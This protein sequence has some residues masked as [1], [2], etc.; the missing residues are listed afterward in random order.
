VFTEPAASAAGKIS[1]SSSPIR[2]FSGRVTLSPSVVVRSSAKA[3]GSSAGLTRMGHVVEIQPEGAEARPVHRGRHA[4]P[5]RVADQHDA[6]RAHVSASSARRNPGK[7]SPTEA[8]P[9]TRTGSEASQAC[10]GEGH[11]QPVIA[12]RVTRATVQPHRAAHDEPVRQ[13]LGVRPQRDQSG[14]QP[15]DAVALLRPK[16]DGA[17][18]LGGALGLRGQ[19]ADQRQL[20]DQVG[21]LAGFHRDRVERGSP[22]PQLARR[23]GTVHT[24]RRRL[25]PGPHPGQR[26]QETGPRRIQ[27]NPFDPD[28]R[29][30]DE[31]RGGDQRRGRR[32]ITGHVQA[33]RAEV[34]PDHR[35]DA[36][37]TSVQSAEPLKE[38]LRVVPRWSGFHHGRLAVRPQPG[39]QD[40]RL[41][42]RAGHRELVPDAV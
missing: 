21:D 2:S 25:H 23:F 36:G 31:R 38:A 14:D 6:V 5:H 32:E 33:E 24:D 29:S 30:G 22:H 18:H 7:E 10:H 1:S 37:L 19:H 3:S 8:M 26:V 27:A 39:Q 13:L 42:L 9:A 4:V 34:R 11:G 28:V 15:G 12:E 41:H 35:H 20:V 40:G 16:L 17:P